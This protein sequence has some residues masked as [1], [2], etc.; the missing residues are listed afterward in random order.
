[1][2]FCFLCDAKLIGEQT[3]VCSSVTPHSN[4]LFS[5][6]IAELMGEE[7]VVIV[8]PDDHTC[9]KCTF[10]LIHMDKLENDLKL[11]KK[12]LLLCIQKKYG[13]LASD[14]SE[15]TLDVIIFLYSISTYICIICINIF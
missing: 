5:Y 13:I 3:R 15:K 9:K 4:S 8:T 14:Y 10:L 1:M 12:V 11:V 2:G 6:K 7:F